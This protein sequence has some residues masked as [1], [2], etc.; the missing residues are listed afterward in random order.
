MTLG[1]GVMAQQL[2]VLAAFPEN[3]VS[4]LTTYIA[5]SQPSATPVPGESDSLAQ[6]YMQLNHQCT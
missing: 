4:I 6:T 5:E 3:L 2:R 1:T